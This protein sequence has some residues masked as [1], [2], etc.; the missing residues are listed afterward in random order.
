MKEKTKSAVKKP[1]VSKAARNEDE[2]QQKLQ[3]ILDAAL[4]VFSAK[5]F[6][7]TRLEDV[8]KKAGVAKGTVYLYVSSKH[9]LF[10]AMIRN[11][12]V[13]TFDMLEVATAVDGLTLE[14]LITILIEWFQVEVLKTKRRE[15]LWLILREA[16]QF[17]ELAHAHHQ[18]IVSRALGI[19]RKRSEAALASGEISHDE[20]VR[21]P[22][23][24][25]APAI[26]A[27][28]WTELF[29]DIEP[30]DVAGMMQA[31]RD[32]LLRSLKGNTP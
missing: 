29:N 9:E 31:Y 32:L 1:R 11:S 28:I 26:V 12:F 21:F 5:G 27:I 22:H 18:L 30:L 14:Q 10:E 23:L 6:A 24:A 8:A 13:P 17:P 7:A 4:E 3:A 2:R 15:M 16:K 20:V 25:I 19:L